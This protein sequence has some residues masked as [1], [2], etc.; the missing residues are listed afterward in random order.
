MAPA[1]RILALHGWDS[2]PEFCRKLWEELSVPP[3]SKDMNLCVSVMPPP[4][5]NKTK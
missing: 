1:K 2:E 4:G 5:T 3:V